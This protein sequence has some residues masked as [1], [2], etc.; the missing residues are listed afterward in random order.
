MGRAKRATNPYRPLRNESIHWTEN[1]YD[2]LGRAIKV[3][4]PDGAEAT[5]SYFGNTVTV[6]DQAGK[7]RRSV[8]NALGQLTRV[9]EPNNAGL[10]DVNN[11]PAQSTNYVYD[12]LNNLIAVNQGVQTRTFQYDS[13][14]RLKQANNPESGIINYLYDNNSNLTSKTDARNV[15]TNYVYDNLN[16]VTNRNY[17]PVNPIPANYQATPN[18]TYTYDDTSVQFSKGKLTQV[19][20]GEISNPFSVTKYLAFDI[21]GRV[22]SSQQMTES[23]EYNPQTYVYNLSG[24]LIEETYPSGRVVKNTLDQ[25]GDL[26]QVQSKKSGGALQNYANAFTYKSAGAVSSLRLGNGKFENTTFNSR[27]QPTQIGLGSSATSQN[28]MKLNFDYGGTDNNGNVKSQTITTP[29]VGNVA[30]FVATQTYS[31]DSLNRLKSAEETIPNQVG[32]KQTFKYDRYGNREFDTTNNNTTTLA[33]GC[34]VAICNP[35]ANPQDNKLVGT[36]YDNVGNTKI[37]ANGQT[38]IYDA[39]NKQV[40]VNNA[41]GIVGQY[42][43]DGDGKRIKKYVPSTLETTIFVYDAGGKMVAEYSTV[44]ASQTE[45]KVSYLTNDHLGSP[46]IT[47]DANGKVISRRDFMPFGEEI[48]RANYGS[49]SVRQKFT[50]YQK[51]DETGLDFAEA[52]YY[53]NTHG[54][55]MAVDPLLASGKSSNPQTFNRYAYSVN[56]PLI[57]TDPTGMQAGTPAPAQTGLELK[58]DFNLKGMTYQPKTE[59]RTYDSGMS[60]SGDLPISYFCTGQNVITLV[61][62]AS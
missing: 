29:T 7:K 36:N 15:V 21:I 49:D 60:V 22:T 47:T 28:L 14:S 27:L 1:F 6:T 52:R 54:R 30:G 11:A 41:S 44:T 46:R 12:T 31:Y 61:L 53:N 38:F 43:Y 50:G 32:W 33:N 25:D 39:E 24:A 23:V 2:S 35:T 48:Q 16:R 18:V 37:D 20:T 17:P 62:S 13:L 5:T 42:F 56:R 3:K 26:A 57:M 51:D 4:T 19:T 40:Q 58:Q 45:A 59:I 55:F 34:P 8:T 9:D 10:L